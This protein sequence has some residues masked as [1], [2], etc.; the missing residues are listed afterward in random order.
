MVVPLDQYSEME[1]LDCVVVLVVAVLRPLRTVSHRGC[2][3]DVPASMRKGSLFC[4]S[5][6]RLVLPCLFDDSRPYRWEGS[7]LRVWLA[8]LC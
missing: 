2:A 8:F 3:M 1:S 5:S 4:M 7:S 6:P